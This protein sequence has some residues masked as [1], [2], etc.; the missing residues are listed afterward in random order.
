MDS[1]VVG[2]LDRYIGLAADAVAL[3]IDDYLGTDF[4]TD[5]GLVSDLQPSDL[6]N[7]ES[8]AGSDSDAA[9]NDEGYRDHQTDCLVGYSCKTCCRYFYLGFSL[10]SV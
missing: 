6:G 8:A 7:A 9:D 3:H 4:G 1:F 5:V 10:T 2:P